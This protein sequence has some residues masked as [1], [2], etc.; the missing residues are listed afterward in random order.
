MS[1]VT[2]FGGG[3]HPANAVAAPASASRLLQG[4]PPTPQVIA[5]LGGLHLKLPVNQKRVTAIGYHGGIGGAMALSPVGSQANEGLVKRLWHSLIGGGGGSPRW[6]QLPGGPGPS[7]SALDVGAPADT[8]VYSP[9]D[10]T[11][12]GILKVIVNG[13]QYG[14]R[15][16]IQP[17]VAPSLVVSVSH[18]RSDPSL[19]VGAL[20]TAAGS[21]LGQV[22]DFSAVEHQ[23]LGE[24]T[25]DSGNHVL[26]EIHPAAT[27]RF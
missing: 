27:L 1:L 19:E 24:Y 3:D 18:L 14:T 25:K 15:I 2:A 26:L 16:D 23:A 11:I 12:V 10:G 4:G 5:R 6:Y 17:T 21:K 7:T 20:V 8:D 9:V 22:R 13:K